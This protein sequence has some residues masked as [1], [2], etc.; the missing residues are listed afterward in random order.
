MSACAMRFQKDWESSVGFPQNSEPVI[1]T[2]S[3]T[4]TFRPCDTATLSSINSL[5]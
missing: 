5:T 3:R 1:C 2:R 4:G